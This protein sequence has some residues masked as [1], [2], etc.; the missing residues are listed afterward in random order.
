V[1]E[2]LKIIAKAGIELF[3][4]LLIVTSYLDHYGPWIY[5]PVIFTVAAFRTIFEGYIDLT[6]IMF[7]LAYQIQNFIVNLIDF[8]FF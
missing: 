5:C 3:C 4:G 2:K 8:A 1:N 7:I 6:L